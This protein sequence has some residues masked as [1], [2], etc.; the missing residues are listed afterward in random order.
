MIR[1]LTT[2]LLSTLLISIVLIY[3]TSPQVYSTLENQNHGIIDSNLTLP[4]RCT[5]PSGIP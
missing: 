3:P 2:I 5:E 1:A 4:N